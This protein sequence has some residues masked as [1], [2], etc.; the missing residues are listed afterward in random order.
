MKRYP[1]LVA[2][3]LAGAL[4]G[5][6]DDRRDASVTVHPPVTAKADAGTHVVRDVTL[7]TRFASYT[8][9]YEAYELDD[10]P[11]KVGFP[12]WAPTIGYTPLGIVGPS[13]C[14]WY[15]QG[16]FHWT[17]DGHNIHE[18]RPRF[19]IVREHGANAMVE[20]V[21]DTPKVTA[22]ARF[23]MTSGSDKLLFLG[24]YTPKEPVQECK[25]RLMSYPATFAQP[26]NRT[27]TTATRTLTSGRNVPL[28]LEQERWVLL[29]D[30]NPGRPADGSAGLLLG[31]TSAFAQVTLDEIGGYA[32]YVDLTL[33]S[34]RRAFALAL[35]ECPSIPDAEETRA[36]F[37]RSADAECEVLARLAQADPEQELAA[38]PMD[39]ERSAQFLR[40]EEA[41][42]TRPVET[43][44]PDPT[45]LAFPWAARLPG[46]PVKVALLCPRWQAYETM[47]LG[48]RLELDVEHLYFDSGTALIAPDYWPYRGQTGIGPLNPGVAERHS[49]RI[50][51]DPQ[52]EVILVAGIH[53]DALPT[54]LRPVILEQVRAGKG[55][56]IAGPPA[57]WPEE[58]FA[59]PDDRLVAPALAAIPWQSLPGLGEGE[60]GR[61]G[62]EAPLKGYRFG[63][64]RVILFTVNTAPYSVLVPANDASEGLSGAA[65]RALA[66]QAAAVLAAAGRS[67]RARLSFD[68][69]PSLKAGVATTLP[70]RL[71]GA[72]AEAL[73]RVQDDHDGVR[74]LARRALRPGN[75]RLALPP[76]PAGRRYFVD[77]LLRDQAGDC[78][79][80]ASTVL[81]APA[82]PRIATVNLSPSRK[83]HPVAPP[84]VA[85]ERGG[86]LT[87]QAR[88]TTVPSGAKPYL[89]WEV[90]DCFNRLL[91]RAVT[92][93]AAN[94]AARAKLPLLRPVTVCHQLDTAL[95]A[96]GR[97]LAVRRD[98]FTIPLPYPYDDF[99][100]LMWS[101][102]GG[103]PVIQ[104]TNR[105]CFNLG[106][107]MMDL[108]HMRGYSDAG[109]AREY[110][111]AARSGLRLVPYVTRIA[112]EVGEGNV[113]RP[114][115]FDNEWLRGEE[116]SIERCCRQAAPYRPP[117]YT[118]GDEN[119]LV[120]GA[121]EVCGAPE[122]MAQFRAWLQARYHTI[123]ALNA[124][125]KTEY[126]SFADIQQPMWL[127]EAVRQQESFAAWFD[128]REFM[129]A[130][131]VR[132]HERLAAAVRA[133]DPGA[134]VGWD[135]LLGYHWQSGYDFSQLTRNL[136]LNQ[137][138]TTEFPQGEWVRSFAR[139]DSLRGEWGNAV[140]DKEDGFT[141]IG[142]HN[143]F[144]GYNSCWWWT[145][146]G[147]DYIP[148]NPDTSLSKPGEWFFRAADE[149]RAGPGKLLL[150]ARRDDS[151]IAILY[152][153]T[154]HFAAALAAQTPGTGAAG[155]WLENH[156]GLLRALEDL[157]TQYRYV[158]AADLETN[159][160]CL[161][162][163]RVLFLPLAVCLSD[164]QVAA[165][166]AFA[167]AGGTVIAD[168]RVGILTRNGVIRDQ[169]PLDDLF[170]V[171]SPAGHAA[172]AQKPQT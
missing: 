107:E 139:P 26:W 30:P 152:S 33:K 102:A 48:R 133:Q 11:A 97:T 63:Q 3:L 37:R 31:D 157:G 93:V 166:R 17:F 153:Q 72:F 165:I 92:P 110:A 121:G 5:A 1:V 164:A 70:L 51:G 103:E 47:E 22:V 61:V 86:T 148:F 101:Y 168:G 23:A 172:F 12:K 9:R 149:L 66:L 76:L 8:L 144:L 135:G 151:G 7:A 137:V 83:V 171:R 120:A 20:Y 45:P 81:A 113:L 52:R 115:L 29:E 138:Y 136:E 4:A 111:L 167:E 42:L 41:L 36:Y 95:I 58:L 117:A 24:S 21:W 156:R 82:G 55:L 64:G 78:A 131:F 85:L 35:Y 126:A 14:L 169:R 84:M 54:R 46:P 71:S 73:V 159:P 67:P 90:R 39:A 132:A 170:G 75:A 74:L 105:L 15:N 143:L 123:A 96:G 127:A 34:D 57:G 56:V 6:Q 119:Y 163:F 53:G 59:Q 125:W 19:R 128:H 122:T 13:D 99:T 124:A 158:A 116:Q 141:A 16:F 146:W 38:L 118:L 129:D 27:V 112:G 140:A 49:L 104:R 69:S 114:G 68:A 161:E 18:Y 134:K 145:S 142:W 40:R 130:A 43:W 91:A 89:R 106:A 80:F 10:D 162:G 62:K 79:G 98:R 155:A 94:G 60:R 88:I 109:A 32:E 77:V 44:R 50:C 150:H 147:C 160:R 2:L 87:C 154:D 25:L 108:C 100:Y 65:D 28:D